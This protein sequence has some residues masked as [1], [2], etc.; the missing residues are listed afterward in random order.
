MTRSILR[1]DAG[2]PL[3]ISS[4]RSSSGKGH[5]YESRRDVQDGMDLGFGFEMETDISSQF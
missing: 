4:A 1:L 3:V 5:K 2:T